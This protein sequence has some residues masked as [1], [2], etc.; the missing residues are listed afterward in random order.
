M[1]SR[2]RARFRTVG[3]AAVLMVGLLAACAGV[4]TRSGPVS[5][6]SRS[7]Q[8]VP[9]TSDPLPVPR[10]GDSPRQIVQDFLRASAE[11][12]GRDTAAKRFLTPS[13]AHEWTNVDEA[14]I[15]KPDKFVQG[16]KSSS[17]VR[18]EYTQV[19]TVN[20]NGSY[21]GTS[22][23]DAQGSYDF[24]LTRLGG[25]WRIDEPPQGGL[26]ITEEDFHRI[27]APIRLYFLNRDQDR[28]VP[29]LRYFL[30][31]TSLANQVAQALID[32]P[33]KTLEPAVDTAIPANVTLREGVV[34]AAPM[35]VDLGGLPDMTGDQLRGMTAQFVWTLDQMRGYLHVEGVKMLADKAP[36]A[37]PGRGSKTQTLDGWLSYDPENFPTDAV[38]TYVVDDDSTIATVEGTR[39]SSTAA[40]HLT[41]VSISPDRRFLAGLRAVRGGV[42]L[43][44]GPYNGRL[45]PVVR[46]AELT[47][48]TW[49]PGDQLLL[50]RNGRDLI[51]VSAAAPHNVQASPAAL[52]AVA[53]VSSLRASLDGSRVAIIGGSRLLYVGVIGGQQNTVSIESV[54]PIIGA[55]PYVEAVAWSGAT[56]LTFIAPPQ[57]NFYTIVWSIS[58]DGQGGPQRISTEGLPGQPVAIAAAPKQLTIVA[59]KEAK[60]GHELWYL[61]TQSDSWAQLDTTD[62]TPLRG[63]NPTYPG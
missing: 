48:P 1:T 26:F 59:P 16:T 35:N 36:I 15:V 55:P 8:A 28:V 33:S 57:D 40:Y 12:G 17:T 14:T 37:I 5:A 24:N 42:V 7:V 56:E 43:Y 58:I 21:T 20:S 47:L 39:L 9:P 41:S 19:G 34:A 62:G 54:Q 18:L 38:S 44:L 30:I 3:A 27:Y 53:P 13:A 23:K 4:P 49:L 45:A 63:S 25:Q 52:A 50:V 60:D 31:S 22:D 10:A 6:P 51:R 11:P 46:G 29:D 61:N 2:R 32:G